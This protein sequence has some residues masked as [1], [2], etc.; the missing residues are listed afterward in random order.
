[1]S[2]IDWDLWLNLP[3]VRIWQACALSL[4]IDP[5]KMKQN[6]DGYITPSGFLFKD[7]SF[8]TIKEKKEFEKRLRLLSSHAIHT[9]HIRIAVLYSKT[10]ASEIYLK[11]F[12]NWALEIIHWGIPRKLAAISEKEEAGKKDTETDEQAKKRWLIHNPDD[13]KPEQSWYTPARY[14]ARQLVEEDPTLLIKRD[15]LASKVSSSLKNAGIKKRGG[16]KPLDPATVKKAF[17][18]VN[19]G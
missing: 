3:T 4:N 12:V 19:F 16:K 17:S 6:P 18:N 7:E 15:V 2:S 5:D 9:Q 1:M 13:P 14:F 11:S 10:A 8:R